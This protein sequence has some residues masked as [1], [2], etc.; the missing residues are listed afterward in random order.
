MRADR[1]WHDHSTHFRRKGLDGH[2]LLGQPSKGRQYRN[3]NYFSIL[4]YYIIS[5]TYQKIGYL[6]CPVH[7]SGLSRIEIVLTCDESRTSQLSLVWGST[8]SIL[9]LG[10][11]LRFLGICTLPKSTKKAIHQIDNQSEKKK[12]ICHQHISAISEFISYCK[13]SIVD[14]YKITLGKAIWYKNNSRI[15]LEFL[16]ISDFSIDDNSIFGTTTV[17]P[18][19]NHQALNCKWKLIWIFSLWLLLLLL[20]KGEYKEV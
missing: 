17:S 13:F 15:S 3:F 14:H 20:W 4:F 2:A 8:P 9:K 11:T 12:S 1:T 10:G 16:K 7:I 6:F 18:V 5:T 19:R